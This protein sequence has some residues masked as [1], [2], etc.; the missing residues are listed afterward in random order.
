MMPRLSAWADRNRKRLALGA[1]IFFVVF[2]FAAMASAGDQT[3]SGE[4]AMDWWFRYLLWYL[5]G[6]WH[7][8]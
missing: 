6:G 7:G 1:I 2:V 5:A 8:F 4:T 3:A